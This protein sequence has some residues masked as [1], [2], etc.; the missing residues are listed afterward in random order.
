MP[1]AFKSLSIPDVILI[2]PKVFP[3]ERGYFL[4][5]FK[6]SDFEKA[7]LPTHFVQENASF[8]KKDVIRGL[9]YQKGAKAQGKLVSVLKGGVWDV[10]V[11]IRKEIGRAHV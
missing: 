7:N 6:A 2:E 11:D 1:F 5:S 9:H 3:D 4:E 8:S 10:A